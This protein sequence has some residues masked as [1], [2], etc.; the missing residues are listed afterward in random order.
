MWNK[1]NMCTY[2]VPTDMRIFPIFHKGETMF[3]PHFVGLNK[4]YYTSNFKEFS[5]IK[6]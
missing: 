6:N 1:K 5:K 3:L 4:K 2:L